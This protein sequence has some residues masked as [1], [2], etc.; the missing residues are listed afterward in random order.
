M[1]RLEFERLCCDASAELGVADTGALGQGFGSTFRDVRFETSF[2]EAG[3]SFL[4]LAELGEI[5]ES[6]RAAVYENM[7]IAQHMTWNRPSLR[8]G[9]DPERRK[10]MLCVE[11]HFGQQTGGAWLAKLMRAVAAQAL[12]WRQTLLAGKVREGGLGHQA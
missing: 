4:L 5:E 11:A 3:D 12:E 6:Q 2:D 8:F 9:F 1:E 7:L 10:V